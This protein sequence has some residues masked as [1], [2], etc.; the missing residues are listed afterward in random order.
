MEPGYRADGTHMNSSS[1]F[2][3]FERFAALEQLVSKIY[4]RF[5]HLFISHPELRD[6][7]WEM[8]QQESQHAAI[9]LAC[10]ALIE[11]YDENSD[12][13]ITESK[14]DE[15]KARLELFLKQGS[16][17]LDV[18]K[19]FR[20][21]LQIEESEMDTIYSKLLSLGGPKIAHTMENL[22]VPASVQRQKLKATL[23]KFCSDALLTT[24]AK[25]L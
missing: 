18:E 19:A 17:T 14:A 25:R 1:N 2:D 7:W 24:D 6:F 22:T 15:L 9:L 4:F 16:P 3:A 23:L 11:N 5:S 13:T 20:I 12:P 8:G 10:K 21:A